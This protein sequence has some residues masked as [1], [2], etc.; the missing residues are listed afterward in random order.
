MIKRKFG[1]KTLNISQG[2]YGS[3]SHKYLNAYDLTGE[4]S[5]IDKFTAYYPFIVIGVHKF[6][7]SNNSG[8][9]NTVHFYDDENDITLALTH[10]NKLDLSV[11]K[12]GKRF[13]VGDVIYYEGMAGKATGKKIAR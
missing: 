5:G 4:D 2:R 9:A 8:F 1:M 3:Y 11:Y 6:N 12:I 13:N 7:H 10:Q